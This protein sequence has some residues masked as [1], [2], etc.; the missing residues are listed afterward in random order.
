M[1]VAINIS[2]TPA[3]TVLEYGLGQSSTKPPLSAQLSPILNN[4]TV[5]TT[6]H[7]WHRKPNTAWDP[8]QVISLTI[9]QT[10]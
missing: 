5:G 7:V 10:N 4:L 1:Q 9:T 3:N 2:V 8:T 6:Y